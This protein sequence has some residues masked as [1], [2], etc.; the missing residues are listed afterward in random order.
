MQ[1]VKYK[2]KEVLLVYILPAKM[3][4]GSNKGKKQYNEEMAYI[5]IP[6]SKIVKI[7]D[8]SYEQS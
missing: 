4:L 3:T 6:F 1:F 8:L 5:G 7:K 2:N